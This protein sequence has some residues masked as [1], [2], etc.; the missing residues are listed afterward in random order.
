[1]SQADADHYDLIVA[2]GGLAGCM[3]AW[4]LAMLEP[5]IKIAIVEAES[6]LGGNHTWSFHQH[7]VSPSQHDWLR[8]FVVHR[9]STQQ[10]RFPQYRRML[11]SAYF[12]IS[13]ESLHRVMVAADRYKLK[14]S[15]K[16]SRVE[17]ARVILENGE[18]ITAQAVL[19]A[20]GPRN[21]DGMVLGFQKFVG[22][23]VSLEQPHSLNAPI[24]MDAT[25]SQQDGYRFLY[26]L[27][28]DDRRMLIE[29]TRYSDGNGLG[30]EDLR[31]AIRQYAEDQG[32][33]IR[34]VEREEEGVLPILLAGDFDRFWPDDENLPARAGLAA[35]LFQPT[36]GYSLPQAVA[37]AD[38]IAAHWPLNGDELAQRTRN[39]TQAFWRKT[40]FFRLLNR[41]LF[42][43]GQ[44]ENRYRVLQRFYRLSEPIITRFYAADLKLHQKARILIGKPP[45]PIREALAVLREKPFFR[46][47]R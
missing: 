22:Q 1:M 35:G 33:R 11:S 44:P 45:V 23:V 28:F 38:E 41:M 43:A 31:I 21:A 17:R 2:G 12:S 18:T 34:A 6:H 46:N 25:V 26:V 19:D 47:N 8:P 4:R 24:I 13:S 16:I 10:V 15:S 9:W 40:R 39:F 5:E 29:D 42:R 3:I 7:D 20:R 14:L 27:P 37:L 32:W 30:V 36:T